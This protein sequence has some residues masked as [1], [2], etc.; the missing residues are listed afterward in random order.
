MFIE[1]TITWVPSGSLGTYGLTQKMCLKKKNLYEIPTLMVVV[2]GVKPAKASRNK[3]CL[4]CLL[5]TGKVDA[6]ATLAVDEINL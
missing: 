3:W 1:P 4:T 2:G 6:E 5:K